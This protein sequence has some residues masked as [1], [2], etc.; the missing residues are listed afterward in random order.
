MF[1]FPPSVTQARGGEKGSYPSRITVNCALPH[2]T[3]A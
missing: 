1:F 3:S 2:R